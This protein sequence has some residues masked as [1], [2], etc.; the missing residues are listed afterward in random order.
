MSEL[1]KWKCHKV[2]SAG[3]IVF[4]DGAGRPD[5]PTNTVFAQVETEDGGN[6]HVDIPFAVVQRKAPS[7][8][9]YYVIYD[10]GYVSWSPA[11]AFEEG[12]APLEMNAI[13]LGAAARAA[14]PEEEY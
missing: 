14:G 4:Y 12:Y 7:I 1:A 5:G 9:D 13:Q 11:K 2:V 10:D 6:I 3:K 8:G